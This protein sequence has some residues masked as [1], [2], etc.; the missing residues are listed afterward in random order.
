VKVPEISNFLKFKNLYRR[1]YVER[2]YKE[3]VNVLPYG[4]M[5]PHMRRVTFFGKD[6]IILSKI[7]LTS[8]MLDLRRKCKVSVEEL[9]MVR[10]RVFSYHDH[11]NAMISNDLYQIKE[12]LR[13][14]DRKPSEWVRLR[15]VLMLEGEY[16]P[17]NFLARS[18]LKGNVAL[19]K[20][21]GGK[22]KYNLNEYIGHESIKKVNNTHFLIWTTNQYLLIPWHGD[23]EPY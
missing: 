13:S 9:D 10:R 14:S 21:A 17:K 8:G 12:T 16:S 7:I 19:I 5:R 22:L 20:M 1:R 23:L 6:F 11:L 4:M 18:G 15:E 2:R 3:C